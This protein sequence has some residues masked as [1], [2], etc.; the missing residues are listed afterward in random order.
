MLEWS[1]IS[2]NRTIAS[3][4]LKAR[5]ETVNTFALYGLVVGALI[6]ALTGYIPPLTVTGLGLGTLVGVIIASQR[7]S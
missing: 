3:L 2:L 4:Q 7:K 6:G 1:R 5:H